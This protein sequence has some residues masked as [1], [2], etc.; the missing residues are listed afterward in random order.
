MTSGLVDQGAVVEARYLRIAALLCVF[1]AA[2]CNRP[3]AVT[4]P[5]SSVELETSARPAY[6]RPGNGRPVQALADGGLF[7]EL[8]ERGSLPGVPRIVRALSWEIRLS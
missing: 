6:V 7:I 8:G 2:G 4:D 3:D 1:L 5:A